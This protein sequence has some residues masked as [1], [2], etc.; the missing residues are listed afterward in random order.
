MESGPVLDLWFRD[1]GTG[2]AVGAYGLCMVT[3][4]GGVTWEQV[5]IVD[6]TGAATDLHLNQ[7]HSLADGRLVIAA[8]AGRLLVSAD[9]RA[10]QPLPSPYE[11]TLFGTLPLD[12]SRLVTFGLRGHL[13]RSLDAGHS[14]M[15]TATGSDTS[16]TDAI[17]LRDGRVVIV[18]MAGTVLVGAADGARFTL[19]QQADRAGLTRVI[20]AGDGALVL[21]GSLGARRLEPTAT[22]GWQ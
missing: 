16:L 6:E 2:Y 12:G 11:G 8:E 13:F 21:L 5:P 18:G 19:H 3:R 14:W 10:W 4:D 15:P 17:R 9:G 7:I 1:A 22:G 20:E